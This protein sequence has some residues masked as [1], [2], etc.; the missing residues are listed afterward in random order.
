ML[1]GY[2]CVLEG[3][4]YSVLVNNIRNHSD[5]LSQGSKGNH[6]QGTSLDEPAK[7]LMHRGPLGEVLCS[8]CFC[9][10][11]YLLITG[12]PTTPVHGKEKD[13]RSAWPFPTLRAKTGPALSIFWA[14]MWPILFHPHDKW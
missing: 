4:A 13:L 2:E 3:D 7:G 14:K 6:G 1:N 11:H 5:L 9:F 12:F 10:G 8:C